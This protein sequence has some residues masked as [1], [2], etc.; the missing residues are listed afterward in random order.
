MPEHTT[1]NKTQQ[2]NN[3][4]STD[5]TRRDFLNK[6]GKLAVVTPVA[7]SVLMTPST[8]AAP[9]SCRGQGTKACR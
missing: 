3:E 6:F 9:K 8:S 5:Q 1:L 2:S 4:T 7:M